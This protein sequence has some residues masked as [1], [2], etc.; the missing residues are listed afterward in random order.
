MTIS[1]ECVRITPEYHLDRHNNP[2]LMYTSV[3]ECL[4]WL[5]GTDCKQYR[6]EFSVTEKTLNR[7]S[8][9]A[10]K[11]MDLIKDAIYSKKRQHIFQGW[12]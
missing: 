10:N 11:M 2:V 12:T 9:V 6:G 3:Y 7:C 4:S 8:I 5:N 1:F